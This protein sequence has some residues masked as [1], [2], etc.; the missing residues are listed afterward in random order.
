M[1][2]ALSVILSP[3]LVLQRREFWCPGA[4]LCKGPITR[5]R[6]CACSRVRTPPQTT[7]NNN[8]GTT[9]ARSRVS[10]TSVAPAAIYSSSVAPAVD[11][12]RAFQHDNMC[13]PTRQSAGMYIRLMLRAVTIAITQHAAQHLP[14]CRRVTERRP[15]QLAA[16]ARAATRRT[17]CVHAPSAAQPTPTQLT[18]SPER[19]WCSVLAPYRSL[20]LTQTRTEARETRHAWRG[21]LSA[22]RLPGSAIGRYRWSLGCT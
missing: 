16:P 11:R 6:S 2:H 5:G 18:C 4:G 22:I 10:H 13:A 17:G 8:P 7:P 19:H 12:P 15:L 14:P 20:G 1:P 9:H 3:T 21:R